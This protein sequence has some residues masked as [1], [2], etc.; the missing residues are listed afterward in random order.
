MIANNPE[1]TTAVALLLKGRENCAA[2]VPETE[3]KREE[4]VSKP[5]QTAPETVAA[6]FITEEEKKETT[7]QRSDGTGE[8]DKKSD[9]GSDKGS[10][11][12]NKNTSNKK[13]EE[14]GPSLFGKWFS[15][16]IDDMSIKINEALKE[17]K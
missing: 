8:S 12:T 3:K 15:K 5:I 7:E 14:E 13:P 1:Y 11:K 9:R 16:K 10:S 6:D 4:P 2:Y 17:E